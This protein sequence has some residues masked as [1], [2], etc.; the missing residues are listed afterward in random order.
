MDGLV[1][2]VLLVTGMVVLGAAASRFG[3]DSRIGSDDPRRP[4]GR[5]TV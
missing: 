5:L 1:V 2:L 3:V 4:E